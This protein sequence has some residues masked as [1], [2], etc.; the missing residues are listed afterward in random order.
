MKK[1]HFRGFDE[2]EN[3]VRPTHRTLP[4]PKPL[5]GAVYLS[6]CGVGEGGEPFRSWGN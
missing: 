3:D 5:L 6:G 2:G 1:H 4:F